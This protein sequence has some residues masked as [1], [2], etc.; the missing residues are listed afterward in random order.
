MK[1]NLTLVFSSCGC[2]R[3]ILVTLKMLLKLAGDIFYA[4]LSSPGTKLN[5]ELRAKFWS[6][7]TGRL[8]AFLFCCGF[9]FFYRW[10]DWWRNLQLIKWHGESAAVWFSWTFITTCLLVYR[11]ETIKRRWSSFKRPHPPPPPVITGGTWVTRG[12][13][14]GPGLDKHRLSGVSRRS[15]SIN[16]LRQPGHW[17]CQTPCCPPTGLAAIN[18]RFQMVHASEPPLVLWQLFVSSLWQQEVVSFS[19]ALLAR[20]RQTR[21][22]LSTNIVCTPIVWGQVRLMRKPFVVFFKKKSCGSLVCSSLPQK[23]GS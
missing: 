13:R 14:L 19:A 8:T 20:S 9:V 6:R 4:F 16:C 22:S 10:L 15:R 23:E 18:K 2:S 3:G 17:S 21:S 5:R 11:T 12:P 1:H 7:Q